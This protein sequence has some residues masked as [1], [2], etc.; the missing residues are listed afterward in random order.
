MHD[1]PLLFLDEP[2]TGLDPQARANLW[3]H[4][5]GLRDEDQRT[6]FLTTHYLEQ[7]DALCDRILVI[8]QGRIVAHG[9]PEELKRGIS[10]DAVT[11]S[12]AGEDHAKRA[13]AATRTL[14]GA[15]PPQLRGADV[16]FRLPRAAEAL[17][18]L[19]RALDAAEVALL[20]V[21]IHR[22]S[23]D[24]VFLSLTG[25]ALRDEPIPA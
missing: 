9:T 20:G 11:L 23:L 5:R 4:V 12:A 21:E 15:T 6:V 25:R 14:P 8:D 7:A 10:G 18:E 24:D 16:S 3:D 22:P 17:P 19:F 1:P 2:T 13:A